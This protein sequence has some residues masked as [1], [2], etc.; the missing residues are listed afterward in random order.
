MRSGWKAGDT[1]QF[2]VQLLQEGVE[3][4]RHPSM[5][6]LNF[7]V[8][9]ETVRSRKLA[10]LTDEPISDGILH[11]LAITTTLDITQIVRRC[12]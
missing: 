6:A 5:G 4:E 9:D 3:L 2:F 8:P 10:G 1:A 7:I 11:Q 12:R